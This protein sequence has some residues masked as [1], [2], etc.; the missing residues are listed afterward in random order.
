MRLSIILIFIS[1]Y[2]FSCKTIT[3]DDTQVITDIP[4]DVELVKISAGAYSSGKYAIEKYIKYDYEIMRFPVTNAQYIE[5][6]KEASESGDISITSS[7]VTGYYSG[8]KKWPSGIYEFIDLDDPD[9]RIVF[10]PPNEFGVVWNRF[11]GKTEGYDNHPVTECTWI[12]ANAYA[13]Y[14]GMKLPNKEEWEK[15]ARANSGLN[16]PW[17]NTFDSTKV[18]FKYSGDIY[19]NDTTPVGFYNGKNN[20]SDSYSPYGIYDMCGNVWEWTDSWNAQSPGKIL[21]GASMRTRLKTDYLGIL[22]YL[23]FYAWFIPSSGYSPNNSSHDIGF[24]TV[25][26]F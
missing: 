14:Y 1:F 12:G 11:D 19:D 16:F 13:K 6:L 25:K 5:Y 24:R 8:D 23:E 17:G 18:N 3:F 15:A 22:D 4:K 7:S 21:K 2:F 10:Y 20:T 9:C 26:I